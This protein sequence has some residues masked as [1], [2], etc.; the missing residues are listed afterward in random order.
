M[1]DE[2]CSDHS[3]TQHTFREEERKRK[4][5]RSFADSYNKC[6]SFAAVLSISDLCFFDGERTVLVKAAAAGAVAIAL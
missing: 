5:G 6:C 4:R 1:L 2:L 3:S